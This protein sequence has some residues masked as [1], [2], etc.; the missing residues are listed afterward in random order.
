MV[1]LG[2][3]PAAAAVV[4]DLLY[5]WVF[6]FVSRAGSLL[7]KDAFLTSQMLLVLLRILM[8]QDAA[9]TTLLF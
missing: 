3:L 2:C 6:Q 5:L 1:K 9:A 7:S 8:F 4:A